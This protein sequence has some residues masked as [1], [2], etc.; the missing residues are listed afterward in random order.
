MV[1]AAIGFPAARW[2]FDRGWALDY[3]DAE[4]HLNIARRI[5]DSRTPGPE[6]LGTVWLPLPHILMIPFAMHRNW[7][8]S[9]FAGV[10]PSVI[11]FVFAGVFLFA[12][13]RRAYRSATAA[14]AA[15]LIFAGNPNMLYL[16][17]TPMTEPMFA[18]TLAALLWTTLWFRDSQ[19]VLPIFAAAAASNAAS[20]TRYEGWFLI[21][22]VALYLLW[23]GQRKWHAVLFGALATLAPLAW[24]AHNRYY[25]G[26]PLEFY[27]GPWSAIAIYHRYLAQGMKPYPGDH[28]WPEALLYYFAAAKLVVGWPALAIG[29]AGVIAAIWKRAWWPILLLTL[30]PAFYVWSMYSSGTPIFVPNLWPNSYYNTRYAI[31]MVPLV[32][33]A[34]AALA[35]AMPKNLRLAGA[36]AL[37]AIPCVSWIVGNQASICWKE[38]EVNSAARREWTRQAADFLVHNYRRGSGIICPFG[39]LTAALREAGIPLGEALHEGNTAEWLAET[40]RPELAMHEEWALVFAGDDAS[41][42]VQRADRRGNHYELRR[43]II[44]KGAPVVEIYQRK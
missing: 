1:L 38:S 5:V 2:C 13:A 6:Q 10:L 36:L 8:Q 40:S 20:L 28:D 44:V 9:G 22:F 35:A 33:F 4:A 18:L 17:S 34:G 29:A 31:A 25:F 7:W 3:G 37:A 39:D 26:N 12:A 32:A 27:D 23:I 16:Q 21:P 42:A 14:L 19:S 41:R 24:F 11:C 43:R 30:V 15:V